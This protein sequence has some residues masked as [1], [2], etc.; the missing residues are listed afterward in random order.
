MQPITLGSSGLSDKQLT[1][2]RDA[3]LDWHGR[4]PCPTGWEAPR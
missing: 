3:W 4:R 2:A 1:G